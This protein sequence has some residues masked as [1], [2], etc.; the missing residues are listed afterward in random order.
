MRM[1]ESENHRLRGELLL[2]E[3]K[4][5]SAAEELFRT[6]QSVASAQGAK[7]FELR[8]VNSLGALMLTQGQPR[9]ARA[10]IEPVYTWFTEG[11]DSGDLK[12]AKELL[13]RAQT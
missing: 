8:A 5:T 10:L 2:L 12:Q 3:G 6:A 9:E 4:T 7:S 1:L 11:F 13:K